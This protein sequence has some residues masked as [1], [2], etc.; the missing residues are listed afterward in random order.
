LYD[1]RVQ[2]DGPL[3]GRLVTVDRAGNVRASRVATIVAGGSTPELLREHVAAVA[4]APVVRGSQ[5]V[6]VSANVAQALI[7]RR[8]SGV[9]P[10]TSQ[11]YYLELRSYVTRA[12]ML[13]VY[14]DTGHGYPDVANDQIALR[15]GIPASLA[16]LPASAPQRLELPIPPHT[17]LCISRMDIV[18]LTPAAR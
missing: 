16:W 6:C 2:V 4:G 13:P 10:V 8:L 9:A 1:Q 17:T 18:T 12:L 7:E 11:P 15:P 3:D 5:Q 14:I